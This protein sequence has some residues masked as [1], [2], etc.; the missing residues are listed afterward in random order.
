MVHQRLGKGYLGTREVKDRG[1][2]SPILYL[3]IGQKCVHKRQRGPIRAPA[4]GGG[5]CGAIGGCYEERYARYGH[6]TVHMKRL[7]V[8]W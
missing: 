6:D 4:W 3:V 1:A 2:D 8:L 7:M 5:G